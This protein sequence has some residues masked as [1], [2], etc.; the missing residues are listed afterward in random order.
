MFYV[1]AFIQEKSYL[2]NMISSCARN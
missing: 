1:H 2:L